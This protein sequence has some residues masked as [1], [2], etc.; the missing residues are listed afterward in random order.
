LQRDYTAAFVLGLKELGYIDGQSIEIQ[1]QFIGDHPGATAS[2]L[3]SELV[4]RG[5]RLI[6][7]SSTPALVAAA[8]ASRTMPVISAGPSRGLQDLG[9]VQSD[10][11][12]GGNVTGVGGYRL[13]AK[14]VDLLKQ[15]L[16]SMRRLAYLR[17][18]TT[19]GTA[20]QTELARVAAAQI[21]VEFAELQASTRE[22]IEPAFQAAFDQGSNALIVSADTL[23]AQG[24]PDAPAVTL[25][26]HYHLPTFYTQVS[27]YVESGGLMGFSPSFIA[28]HR[29]AAAYVDKILKGADV[30]SLPV[31]QATT[32]DF[33]I[34]LRTAEALGITVPE[35]VRLQATQ[36]LR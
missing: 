34:N 36:V 21:G 14:A 16:P 31:E 20:Q 33:A 26:I 17:N 4:T 6:V 12:P 10:A 19:P 35:E 27:G 13:D 32:F 29:R 18:P 7:T 22:Q 23:F 8:Q 9:L 1:W 25:P 3:A 2:S 11:H 30:A 5:V 15:T 28:T 24:L